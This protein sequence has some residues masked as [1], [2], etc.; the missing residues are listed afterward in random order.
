MNLNVHQ[1]L[2][3]YSEGH[4][5]LACSV[6]LPTKDARLMLVMSDVSGP[7]IAPLGIP[8]LTGYPLVESGLYALARTWPAPEMSRPGCVWTHTLLVGFADLAAMASPASLAEL[9]K[10]PS[11]VDLLTP[12]AADIGL[13][14]NDPIST[15][16]LSSEALMW[17]AKFA[18]GLYEHP[19]AQVWAR[20]TEGQAVDDAV[21]R[22]WDQQWPRLKRTFRFCTLTSRDRSQEGVPFDL[23][24]RPS[25]DSSSHLRFTS[26]HEGVE[27]ASA[28]PSPWLNDLLADAQAPNSS[29]LRQFL[30]K[31]GADM[32]GG[33]EAMRPFCDLHAALATGDEQGLSDA[34]ARVESSPL[35]SNSDLTRTIVAQAAIASL[36]S[37]SDYVLDFV[38]DNFP[39]LG[40]HA[41]QERQETFTQL[42]WDRDPRRL[43]AFSAEA[44]EA[45][46]KAVRAGAHSIAPADILRQL[47]K[48]TDLGEPLVALVPF[49]AEHSAFWKATQLLPLTAA[50][51]GIELSKPAVLSAMVSG[52]RDQKAIQSALQAVGVLPTLH[53][54]QRQLETPDLELA[55]V[56]L[57]NACGEPNAVA[58]FLASTSPPSRKMVQLLAE[59]L[60]P[61][62]VPNEV[63]ADPWWLTLQALEQVEGALPMDL[64]VYGFQ[65]ALGRRSRNVE[66]LFKLTFEPLHGAVSQRALPSEAWRRL[67]SWLP[68]APFGQEWDDAIRLRRAVALRCNDIQMRADGFVQLVSSD[69]VFS[70]LLD[71]VWQLWGGP[72]YVRSMNDSLL[73]SERHRA[74]PRSKQLKSF[75][76]E[77]SKFW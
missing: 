43:L 70:Q 35:L 34:V 9:F 59:F 13:L 30:R 56:W 4:R 27:A 50:R 36:S 3:G 54:I 76:K 71:E 23:Q 77:H 6:Q 69:A 33:R 37:A 58:Q 25:S 2:H 72:R 63:G 40:E 17:F 66:E 7:G 45:V 67:E 65:R 19:D 46:G 29:T 10:R 20:R 57:G 24:L 8:Y 73:A 22:L 44:G 15:P 21:L 75:V 12:Y 11:S 68:S 28:V 52:L 42:L 39:R 48:L 51:H 49:V 5:Q 55:R 16:P 32:L 14:A 74:S 1:A 26:S 38:I 41:I 31:L 47:E 61:D 18:S 64:L 62:S 53:V 60:P